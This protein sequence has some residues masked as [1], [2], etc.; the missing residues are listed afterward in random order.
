MDAPDQEPALLS[1]LLTKA[2]VQS[3]T[4]EEFLAT[5]GA[6][7]CCTSLRVERV[8]LSLHTLHP[9]FRARTYLWQQRTRRVSMI[10]WPHGL[11][12]RPGYY[13]SP[14][15]HVHSTGTEL[16]VKGLQTVDPHPCDLYGQLRAEGYTDYLI[17][18]LAFG[19]G[20]INT[21]SIGTKL[22]SGFASQGL[23]RFHELTDLFVVILERYAALE[24]MNV[25]LDTYLGRSA[26]RE[27]LKGRIRS[28]TGE[29]IEAA[30]L[31][32]D[33][34]DFTAHAARLDALG[35]VR[36]LNAYFDCL[37]GPIEANG[38]YV[39]KFIGDAVLGFFPILPDV[40]KPKPL[41]AI[42][43]IRQR[44]AELNQARKAGDEPPLRHALCGHFGRV[45]YGNV[46]STERLDFTVI[47]EAVNLTSRCLDTAKLLGADYVFTRAFTEQFG[48]EMF[49]SI[50]RHTLKGIPEPLE[51]FKLPPETTTQMKVEISAAY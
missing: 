29:E 21:L 31:F 11:K 23:G 19:D 12:N 27:I 50:G 17:V 36:L 48:S 18:P 38:G 9:A 47:G 34:D 7:L 51:L 3:H 42:L 32:A 4:L 44:L 10:E 49:V 26:A 8:F 6:M 43:A 30:I 41:D 45:L 39:L 35:T 28:G 20:T 37:V 46:G 15:F 16:R 13:N 5:V 22:P 24:T 25:A 1:K 40:N 33:L 14:D 2:A